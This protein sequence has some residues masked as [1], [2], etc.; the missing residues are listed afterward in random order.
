MV[1]PVDFAKNT[2]TPT[3]HQCQVKAPTFRRKAPTFRRLFADFPTACKLKAAE[4]EVSAPL[5]G[6]PCLAFTVLVK[7][8]KDAE[9]GLANFRRFKKDQR[10]FITARAGT[11][12]VAGRRATGPG[13][14]CRLFAATGRMGFVVADQPWLECGCRRPGVAARLRIASAPGS[15]QTRGHS[16]RA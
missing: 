11:V 5:A 7:V 16:V 15:P 10:C 3:R 13:R 1:S 9:R 12:L 14:A 8:R 4:C 6:Q 2:S